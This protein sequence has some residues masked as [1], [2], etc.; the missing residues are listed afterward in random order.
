MA[1]S[2]SITNLVYGLLIDSTGITYRGSDKGDAPI[3]VVNGQKEEI[4]YLK[5][6]MSLSLYGVSFHRKIY[7]PSCVKAELLISMT[8]RPPKVVE[9]TGML[10]RRKVALEVSKTEENKTGTYTVA[11]NFY[12]HEISPQYETERKNDGCLGEVT[13]YYIYVKLEMYS[14]DKMLTINKFSKAY[15]GKRLCDDILS[16]MAGDFVLKSRTT[17]G[18]KPTDI[19]TPLAWEKGSLQTLSYEDNDHQAIEMLH[20]YL[21]QYNESFYEFLTR[22]ANRCGE[23]LYFE[24]G[25]LCVG[26]PNKKV[27]EVA[28]PKRVI[29]Q[30]ISE[31]PLNVH[32]FARDT[33]NQWND[34][35]KTYMPDGDALNTDDVEKNS[36]G[37]P[38]D[39]YAELSDEE[40]D[41]YYGHFY[42]SEIASEDFYMLLYKDKFARDSFVDT[43]WGETDEQLMEVLS[44][45]LN[46]TTLVDL[47]KSSVDK[48]GMGAIR[49]ALECGEATKE[50]NEMVAEAALD[51]NNKYA[52]MLAKVDD[53][54]SHW[55]TLNYY[56]DIRRYEDEQ[57]RKIVCV[58]MGTDFLDVKLG[59]QI[60]LPND[61]QTYVVIRVEMQ[62]KQNWERSYEGFFD[63]DTA[64]SGNASA[65]QSQ[66]FYAIPKQTA[67][68][69]Y[70]PPVLPGKPFRQSGPLP[71]YVIDSDDPKGQGR[72]RVRYAWQP[73]LK[74]Y[75]KV[76]EEHEEDREKTGEEK[77]KAL[78]T[79][80]KYADVKEGEDGS[81]EIITMKSGADRSKYESA[82]N[83][84]NEKKKAFQEHDEPYSRA[85][86]QKQAEEEATP[87]I[88]MAM[89]MATTGG[90]MYFK[91]E[92][93][94]EVMV[95]FENGNIERPY[96]VGALYSKN[97]VAPGDARTI[98]SKNGHTIKMD[99]PDDGSDFL[100]GLYP[101]LDFLSSYKIFTL[102]DKL[103]GLKKGGWNSFLGGIEMTDK[104]GMYNISMSSH[105]R[106]INISSPFGEVKI[107]ALTGISIEA[108]NGNVSI[109]G[110]NV[111][112]AAHNNLTITSGMNV[113]SKGYWAGA[114]DAKEWGKALGEVVGGGTVGQ[115]LDLSLIRSL[116]EVFIRP[117]DGTLQIHSHRFMKLE[118]GE[119][120]A[121]IPL[122]NYVER[123]REDELENA[124]MHTFIKVMISIGEPLDKFISGFVPLFNDL[125]SKREA[126][127]TH[128]E[129]TTPDLKRPAAVDDLVKSCFDPNVREITYEYKDDIEDEQKT[130]IEAKLDALLEASKNMQ[131][132]ADTYKDCYKEKLESL[133]TTTALT[134]ADVSPVLEWDNDTNTIFRKVKDVQKCATEVKAGLFTSELET[135][136]FDGCKQPLKR[137]MAHLIFEKARADEDLFKGFKVLQPSYE[138]GQSPAADKYDDLNWAKYLKG[139][140]FERKEEEDGTVWSNFVEGLKDAAS[141]AL[142]NV[143][144]I[145]RDIWSPE[146]NGDIFFSNSKDLTISFEKNG[147]TKKYDNEEYFDE[148]GHVITRFV[149]DLTF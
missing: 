38:E 74:P 15:L 77:D 148:D 147:S 108:P 63:D 113:E 21:V 11:E 12:I 17:V 40:K 91:P 118:S 72:V 121:H 127:K 48:F 55:L 26:L 75:E 138:N 85:E 69:K 94:D 30:Q 132:Y 24:N 146:A 136:N 102:S 125:R 87:W 62:A 51:S 134:A 143:Y 43:W 144:P 109:V 81:D 114:K 93:G 28:N 115:F 60:T 124:S 50:G 128:F 37:F 105:E 64:A 27:K 126:L 20:P 137:R 35:K 49:A 140:A 79:L 18:N 129:G 54:P 53:N 34:E 6:K 86:E 61:D 99:D 58:D 119:G 76:M 16:G 101:G 96:V 23:F 112:I 149:T 9:L 13:N 25:K 46:S 10:L 33:V 47:I 68:G 73:T 67:N 52:V 78:E 123:K 44:D 111:E 41:K 2:D 70:Y 5:K 14:L 116:L 100:Q 32:G 97:A 90:G 141:D 22:V 56:S 84:Y 71:A 66:K 7:E 82:L 92:K 36:A 59:D 8:E 39:A 139:F 107:G 135:Q 142:E 57:M 122:S 83:E 65:Q 19:S 42:N 106:S 110:K 133:G 145:E 95:D 31:G 88:R 104:Y 3:H 120:E 4:S 89:P 131:A 29:Y 45:V 80:K 98:V 130:T 1:S 117:V 103:K